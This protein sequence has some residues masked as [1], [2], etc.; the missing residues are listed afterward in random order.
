MKSDLGRELRAARERSGASLRSVATAVG[1]SPSLLSQV[2]TG[3]VHPS[4]STLYAIVSHLGVSLDDLLSRAS[5]PGSAD[6][7]TARDAAARRDPAVQRAAD[8]PLIEMENG[9]TWERLATGGRRAVDPLVVTYGPGGSSSVEGRL[10]RHSGWEYG[11]MIEGE[12]TLLLDFERHRLRP[13]DSVSFE[14][15][16]PH[17]YLNETDAP[18]RGLFFVLGRVDPEL[19]PVPEAVVPAADR[20]RS[21]VDVLAVIQDLRGPVR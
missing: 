8:N 5:L 17:L 2:E 18:A 6:P 19:S 4:V 20:P 14:S 9:V 15:Q 7:D 13:G 3:K 11:Y 10:M 12:L 16:R 21:A 1:I